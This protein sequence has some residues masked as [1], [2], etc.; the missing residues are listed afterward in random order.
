[1]SRQ[2]IVPLVGAGLVLAGVVAYRSSR[3]TPSEAASE[4]T[5]A[6]PA[7]RAERV[8]RADQEQGLARCG[9]LLEDA[10]PT[11][12]PT[13]ATLMRECAG[14]YA[15]R[16]CRDVLRE[17]EFSRPRVHEV[18]SA[19]YCD[20][21]RDPPSFCTRELPSDAEFL[22]QFADFSEVVLRRDLRRVMDRE[23]AE[24]IATL[25][26]QLIRDQAAR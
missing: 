22:Q 2:V 18:C 3:T 19:A 8:S 17:G 25:M 13:F 11:S 26:G 21:L 24:E 20:E 15:V 23:G 9:D 10:G 12:T 16:A 14:L 1:M 6:P 4:R 5:E 7:P